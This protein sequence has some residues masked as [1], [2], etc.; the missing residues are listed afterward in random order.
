MLASSMVMVF[1]LIS[2]V[3]IDRVRDNGACPI[4]NDPFQIF[5][6]TNGYQEIQGAN[7][8]EAGKQNVKESK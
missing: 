5:R 7:E 2:C 8:K 1:S 6:D 4:G 3:P